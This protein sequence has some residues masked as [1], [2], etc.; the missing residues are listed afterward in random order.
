MKPST[1]MVH[2]KPIRFCRAPFRAEKTIVPIPP[3]VVATP[4]ASP[5]RLRNQLLMEPRLGVRIAEEERPPRMLKP[6]MN[7]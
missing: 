1:R 4:V 7:W 5:R 3:E 6:R 2:G